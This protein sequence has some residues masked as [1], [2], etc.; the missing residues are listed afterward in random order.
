MEEA[1]GRVGRGLILR[2]DLADD[3]RIGLFRQHRFVAVVNKLETACVGQGQACVGQGQAS[4]VL[5][6]VVAWVLREGALVGHR[7]GGAGHLGRIGLVAEVGQKLQPDEAVARAGAVGRVFKGHLGR[8]VGYGEARKRQHRALLCQP[9]IEQ[10]AG[11]LP[12]ALGQ[13]ADPAV[14]N[15]GACIQKE[16]TVRVDLVPGD[17][18]LETDERLGEGLGTADHQGAVP[19]GPGA[20]GREGLGRIPGAVGRQEAEGA[21]ARR[22]GEETGVLYPSR[23]KQGECARR[24]IRRILEVK[25]ELGHGQAR[26]IACAVLLRVNRRVE[27]RHRRLIAIEREEGEQTVGWKVRRSIDAE[28]EARGLVPAVLRREA[29]AHMGDEDLC[30]RL[31]EIQ[32]QEHEA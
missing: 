29:D 17:V 6:V 15:V 21:Q 3:R 10:I 32:G 1:G 7:D 20:E 28:H 26:G 24:R 22:T 4:V 12:G 18:E 2:R 16:V 19:P 23:A 13:V 5:L 25:G 30:E 11:G 27:G 14:V 8:A 31:V 9:Q